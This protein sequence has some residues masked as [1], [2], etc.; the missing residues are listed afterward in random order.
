MI[1]AGMYGLNS[2]TLFEI[3]F[4]FDIFVYHVHAFP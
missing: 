4:I 3:S 2:I 1:I